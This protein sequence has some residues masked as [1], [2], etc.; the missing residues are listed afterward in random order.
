[1]D[2]IFLG[3]ITPTPSSYQ[4]KR[5]A[6]HLHAFY[7]DMLPLYATYISHIPEEHDLFISIPAPLDYDEDSIR[8]TFSQDEHIGRITV[9]HTPNRGRD[10]APMICTFWEELKD[11]DFLLHLHTKKSPHLNYPNNWGLFMLEHL[12]EDSHIVACILTVLAQDGYLLA[13]QD[14]HDDPN[15]SGWGTKNCNLRL[16]QELIDKSSL[17]INLKTEYPTIDYPQGTF[18][19]CHTEALSRLAE[20]GLDYNDFPAE[21]I[22]VD[23]TLA[24]A[25]ERL[26]CLW[27]RDLLTTDGRQM[28]AYKIENRMDT[29][30]MG[31]MLNLRE[32]LRI[33]KEKNRKHLA[34]LR[35]LAIVCAALLI[36]AVLSALL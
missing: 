7:L 5:I 29:I 13:P 23:G 12:L 4:G 20:I 25:L 3:D 11:Y 14:L 24:H 22:G 28:R 17:R 1:M 30:Y 35:V 6:V 34:Q 27:G 19:W 18:F 36:Y 21:P 2:K 10:I 15:P 31:E 32:K 9:A 16:A 26:F 8:E 33:T